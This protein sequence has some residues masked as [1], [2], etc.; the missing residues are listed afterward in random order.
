MS[1]V[2]L[3]KFYDGKTKFNV[4]IS[5]VSR[6]V[7][8]K[9]VETPYGIFPLRFFFSEAMLTFDGDEV[10]THE[11]RKIIFDAINEEDR[12]NLKITIEDTGIGIDE[13]KINHI[14]DKY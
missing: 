4:D 14:F 13:E 2:G 3:N 10:S 6:V 11:I 5:T 7:R 12:N 9:Y 1:S 8:Q